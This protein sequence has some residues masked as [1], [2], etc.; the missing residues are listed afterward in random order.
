MVENTRTYNTR[1]FIILTAVIGFLFIFKNTISVFLLN[2]GDSI[3]YNSLAFCIGYGLFVLLTLAIALRS[4]ANKYIPHKSITFFIVIILVFYCYLRFVESDN[5]S[6]IA[7]NTL[8]KYADLVFAVG[9]I[10]GINLL[11]VHLKK[12]KE[13]GRPFFLEDK[14]FEEGE[15][16]NEKI[17][18]KLI[19]SLTGF[20]PE[21][22]FTI[23]INAIWG[24]GKSS[25]LNKFKT[26][27]S[28]KNPD[29]IVF[30]YRVWKNK[31]VNAIIENFFE[32]LNTSLKPFSGELDSEFKGYVDAI[33]QLPSTE[34]SKLM[35]MGR[36]AINGKESLEKHFTVINNSISKIDK[37]III[38]LDD[39]DR[40]EREEIL[41]TLKLIR[42]LSDFNNLVFVV[43]YDRQYLVE[44]IQ[45]PKENYLDKVFNVEIN[46]LPFDKNLITQSLFKEIDILYPNEKSE[47][48]TQN[49]NSAFKSLFDVGFK[50]FVIDVPMAAMTKEP[51]TKYELNYLDF[52]GTFR[53]IK[54][55]LNEFRFNESF[56]ATRSDV[57]PSEYILLRLL[58]YKYRYVQDLILN[59]LDS[60]LITG[61]IDWVNDK[62]QTGNM[63]SQDVWLYNEESKNKVR[64]ALDKIKCSD[65]FAVVNAVLCRLFGENPLEYYKNNQNTI[66]KIYYT[67]LYLRNDI[68][69]GNIAISQIQEAFENNELHLLVKE[70]GENPSKK[71]FTIQNELKY[72]VF[73][74]EV[75]TKEQFQDVVLS[76]QMFMS[77]GLHNDDEMVL[78]IL[79]NGLEQ[80]YKK[81]RKGFLEMI[82]QVLSRCDIGYFDRLFS[83]ININ[84]KRKEQKVEYGKS[85]IVEYKSN[86]F[87]AQELENLLLN[88]LKAF[89]KQKKH[90][91]EII[92]IYHLL[93]EKITADKNIIRP[94]EANQ[95][96]KRE[97]ENSLE[98]YYKTSLFTMI[99]DRADS[100]EGEVVGYQPNDFLAQIFSSEQSYN[101][102]IKNI[103]SKSQLEQHKQ[104]GI[105]NL[106]V[107][108]KSL[109]LKEKDE[110]VKLQKTIKTLEKYVLKGHKPLNAKEYDLI[111]NDSD[112]RL[113]KIY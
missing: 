4:C 13:K 71:E 76:L 72:F 30:W 66:S 28:K 95:I 7:E 68:A 39:M 87:K 54:R 40:L 46:L 3:D 59:K 43:G 19:K 75:N 22:A 92:E 96:L 41:S 6:F 31:G 62:I 16:I 42:T 64:I 48:D 74:N 105:N 5:I 56:L 63:F 84:E 51:C 73:K 34:I 57:I 86:F 1:F 15:L 24:Y 29:A 37:Q 81:D 44:T 20:R 52:V 88:K 11:L 113:Y 85:G 77:E 89:V 97:I 83:D 60:F 25:F 14:L 53:D 55:F 32:E 8:I 49:L 111:W 58:T 70:I 107:F 10:F 2:V 67:N 106:L 91:D 98:I 93:I 78:E 21:I 99:S 80:F 17:L 100:R 33:L 9:L 94:F 61:K 27:Y 36:D 47:I 79:N 109:K 12:P 108:L 112:S 23:G 104:D 82:G 110:Q 26:D 102:L 65:D 69:A 101:K 45:K 90:V 18:Q 35:T 103:D 38:L 50:Q